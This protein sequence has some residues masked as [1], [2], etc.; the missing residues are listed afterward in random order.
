MRVA[1]VDV[2]TNSVRLLVADAAGPARLR[3]VLRRTEITRLGRGVDRTGQLDPAALARTLEVLGGYGEQLRGLGATRVRVV[4]TSASRDASDRA[5]FVAGVVARLGVEP[6]VVSGDEEATLAFAGATTGLAAAAPDLGRPWLVADVGG[7][8]TE[9][10]LGDGSGRPVGCSVDVGSVRLT[11]RH[12]AADPPTAGQVRGA[13]AD[14]DVALALVRETVPVE[15]AATLVGVAGSVTTVAALAMGL[16]R[17][18]SD[19]VHLA[20][21]P[22]ADVR[23]VAGR[24]L[25]MT[26]DERAALAVVPAGRVDVIAAG[27]LI[28]SRLVDALGVEVLVASERDILDGIALSLL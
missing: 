26:R 23:A 27:A 24:L 22:A 17:Y 11:E 1:A 19:R 4:A 2:G 9:L 16:E 25:A 13:E 12:F 18:D 5:G 14:I 7:G 20:R 6:E 15:R 8:S 3:E 21:V 10:V 28:V